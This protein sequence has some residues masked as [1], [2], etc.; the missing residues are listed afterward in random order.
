MFDHFCLYCYRDVDVDNDSW[1]EE[2][3]PWTADKDVLNEPIQYKEDKNV[4][5]VSF[6]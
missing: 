5:Y 6:E 2:S 4:P 1:L 3:V